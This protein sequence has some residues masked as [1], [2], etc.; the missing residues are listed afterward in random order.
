[1]SLQAEKGLLAQIA[2]LKLAKRELAAS[3][4]NQ[5][6][7]DETKKALAE[8]RG[9]V[10][11]KESAISEL[12]N[13]V[14][15]LRLATSLG[16]SV[17]D[18]KTSTIQVPNKKIAGSVVG[19]GGKTL[20]ALEST[21]LVKAD[22]NKS[23]LLLTL[24]GT[25]EGIAQATSAVDDVTSQIESTHAYPPHVI[26][27]FLKSRRFTLSSIQLASTCLHIACNRSS[28]SLK[29]TGRP[30]AVERA[31]EMVEEMELVEGG[32]VMD[33]KEKGILIGKG[34][35]TIKQLE[36]GE[37]QLLFLFFFLLL[38]LSLCFL[39]LSSPF[40]LSDFLLPPFPSIF[41]SP[42]STTSISRF[43]PRLPP[44]PRPPTTWPR[45]QTT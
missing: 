14:Q 24:T 35:A 34:G 6:A 37:F 1:M 18:L 42:Q 31:K 3:T 13:M 32:M 26:S 22:L 5:A 17:S 20:S 33:K 45:P 9:G 16:C 29:F 36:E 41:V 30:E 21:C 40:L 43:S 19:K 27:A 44:R 8:R 7:I 2:K 38:S 28:S 39:L 15:K 11:A 4:A 25:A 12:A 23:T 10:R